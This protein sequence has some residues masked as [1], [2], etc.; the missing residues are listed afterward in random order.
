LSQFFAKTSLKGKKD[1]YFYQSHMGGIYTSPKFYDNDDLYC[2]K[3]GD[4]DWYLGKA[5]SLE[6]AWKLLEPETATVPFPCNDCPR[7]TDP[8]DPECETCELAKA[9][10]ESSGN[11]SVIYIMDLLAKNFQIKNPTYIYMIE[12]DKSKNACVVKWLEKN[13]A[14]E[15]QVHEI[16][17]CFCYEDRLKDMIAR[18]LIAYF[19]TFEDFTEEKEFELASFSQNNINYIIYIRETSAVKTEHAEYYNDGWYGFVKISELNPTP[20][21][22]PVLEYIRKT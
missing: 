17:R 12:L 2:D 1:M 8:D 21:D 20:Q 14:S 15:K 11:Y 19:G 9:Y 10:D 18:E 16:P 13:K 4:S 22:M 3:C 6:E 7:R 5:D